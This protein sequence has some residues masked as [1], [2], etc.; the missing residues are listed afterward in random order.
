MLKLLKAPAESNFIAGYK[1]RKCM[2][3]WRPLVYKLEGAEQQEKHLCTVDH[4]E[5]ELLLIVEN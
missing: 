3:N 2:K 4:H 1:L 5:C